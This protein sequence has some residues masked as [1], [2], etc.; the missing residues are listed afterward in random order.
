MSLGRPMKTHLKTPCFVSIPGISPTVSQSKR[1]SAPQLTFLIVE[2]LVPPLKLLGTEIPWSPIAKF[3]GM[4]FTRI[5]C[6]TPH[7]SNIKLKAL[8]SLYSL[9]VEM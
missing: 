2:T 8:C 6:F 5:L 3:L 7:I 1:L 9:K 4:W